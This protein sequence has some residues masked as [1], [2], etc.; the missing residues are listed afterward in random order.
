MKPLKFARV[1]SCDGLRV[2]AQGATVEDKS[3][4]VRITSHC[5]NACTFCIA[6]EDMKVRHKFDLEAVVAKTLES[7]ATTLSL[8]GGEPLLFLERCRDYLLRVKPPVEEVY[9]TTALP[10]TVERQPDLFQEVW[11]LTDYF[12]VS[13]QSLDDEVNNALMK[14]KGTFSSVACLRGLLERPGAQEK[15][16]VNLNLVQGG[17]DTQEKFLAAVFHLREWGLKK[18]RV[19]ELMHAPASYVNFERMMGLTLPS[20]YSGGCKS[21]L[22][23]EGMDVLLK[24][25]CFL[26][27]KSLEATW[28]D[29]AK[30][31]E[32]LAHPEAYST[33]GWRILYEQGDYSL[34]WREARPEAGD[35][36]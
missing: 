30:V 25:S 17:V 20:P 3:L 5:H 18:L 28:D 11:D 34:K 9:I 15:L 7:G 10:A 19:N 21:S 35:S 36:L 27:E 16:T 6:A 23:V 4:S 33:P 32:K 31:R 14:S 22:E 8:V 24:R 1:N 29:A 12:T 2:D 26:V 13:L